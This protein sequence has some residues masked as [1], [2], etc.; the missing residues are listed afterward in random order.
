MHNRTAHVLLLAAT[1]IACC[2]SAFAASDA[3][4]DFQTQIAPLL[5]RR[6]VECHQERE[7]SGNLLLTTRD[8]LLKGGDSG[9][10]VDLKAATESLLLH[11]VRDGEMPPENQGKSQRLPATEIELLERW[12][13]AG[14]K[15]PAKRRLDL[16]ERTNDARAGRDWW[17]LQSIK[18]PAIPQISGRVQPA[19]KIDAFVLARLAKQ[20]M[21]PAP[22]A[23]K[24]TRIRRLYYDLIGLP[25]T[26]EQ[27]ARFEKD[28]SPTAWEDAIDRLLASDHYG[29]RW[30]RYWLDLVRYADTS[31]YERDQEKPFAWKYRD[32]VVNALNSDMPYNRFIVE[33]LAGDEVPERTEQSVIATGFLRLGTWNDEPND[34]LDY[35]YDRLEDLVHTT[36]SAFLGMTVKC[37]RCH[38]HKFD[39]ITQEDYYRMGSAFWAGPVAPR[40]RELLGGPSQGEL[41]FANV[42]GWSDVGRVPKPLH[43]LKSGEREHKLQ[44]VIPASL[45][46]LPS[47]EHV[48]DPPP[49]GAKTSHRRLQLARW[50]ANEDNPLTARVLVNRIWQHHFGHGL[51]RSPNNFGFLA[52]PPTHPKLL[53]WLAAEFVSG[54]WTI[55]R[56]HKL[57]LTS[58]TWQ[59]A[60]VHP[61]FADYQKRDAGN[62][63]LWRAERRRLDAE[64]LR[65]SMLAVSQELDKTLGGPGFRP[66]ISPEAL[67]GLSKKSAAWKASPLYEQSRRSLYIFS[68]RGLLPPMMTTFDFCDTTQSS[69]KRSST[70][71]PTQALALMNNQ[72]VHKRSKTL[73]RTITE[74]SNDAKAQVVKLWTQ[75]YGRE[76]TS[77]ELRIAVQ[78]VSVQARRFESATLEQIEGRENDDKQRIG[79]LG[80]A[81]VLHLRADRG[82][83]ADGAGQVKTW[84]DQSGQNHHASQ[85]AESRQPTLKKDAFGK[86]KAAVSFDGK[87]SFLHLAGKILREQECTIIAVVND[88]K[89]SRHRAI[90][91]NWN[92]S[93]GN[94]TSSLFLGLTS[95]NTIRFS[96]AA[97]NAGQIR[98]SNKPFVITAINGPGR[99]AVYQNGRQLFSR[100]SP[101]PT[102]NL[103]TNWVV[104]QQGN[105]GGE[106]WHG[107]IAELRVYASALTVAERMSV[108]QSVAARNGIA[109][110]ALSDARDEM[111]AS[112]RSSD[113]LALASLAHVLLNS[114]EFLYVD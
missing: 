89:T 86:G 97:A 26:R 19:N 107:G 83:T 7:P 3:P 5:I 12:I 72:F 113:E 103:S 98:D 76:P 17:S 40:G 1:T 93:A 42:L 20:G 52:D 78:H 8:G 106:Y 53:D 11:R 95:K 101:L 100:N 46:M 51:V 99:S 64:A 85:L 70:T 57:I 39:P 14:A 16:F 109:L 55:K 66:T 75:V 74:S 69:G 48:F 87:G 49:P 58:K 77:A 31:G 79:K 37:A 15:W 92:G 61:Q 68:K 33:Q 88:L 91:S 114:N 82:L 44:Q 43:V 108:E 104:G 105:I 29:E 27:I 60:S 38:S 13:A 36:S 81:L 28:E 84:M 73:A 41:G 25:P 63:L 59:Q 23:D 62:H 4:P 112:T 6:C 80:N 67:E 96:D 34:P 54:D 90:L 9:L 102:R 2:G 47:I 45:S 56:L 24:R 110:I 22:T 50:I 18:R 65:D 10:A 32:W 71:A 21:T 30:G 111:A 94:S 35:Q